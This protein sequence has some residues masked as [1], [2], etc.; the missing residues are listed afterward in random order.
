M[1]R[2]TAMAVDFARLILPAGVA[3]YLEATA[4][5][6]PADIFGI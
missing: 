5:L 3:S 6:L 4:A 1:A 2:S